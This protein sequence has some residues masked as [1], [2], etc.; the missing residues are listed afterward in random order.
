LAARMAGREPMTVEFSRDATNMGP[1][2]YVWSMNMQ[3][4]DLTPS[5]RAYLGAELL[6]VMRQGTYSP[7]RTGVSTFVPTEKPYKEDRRQAA[8]KARVSIGYVQEAA[9]LKHED[10]EAFQKVKTGEKTLREATRSKRERSREI[11]QAVNRISFVIGAEARDMIIEGEVKIKPKQLVDFAGKST[12]AIKTIWP[13]ML[14]GISYKDAC[15]STGGA[16][17]NLSS[18]LDNLTAKSIEQCGGPRKKSK[19]LTVVID[20]W[21]LSVERIKL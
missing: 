11:E 2:E 8:A 14:E 9:T 13:L 19:V 20:D 15:K 3:R 4:R 5:Q 7:A 6:E 16:I 21:R 17:L 12:T 10:P 1:V 18:T